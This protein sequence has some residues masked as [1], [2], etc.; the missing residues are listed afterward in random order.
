MADLLIRCGANVEAQD[1]MGWTPL[2]WAAYKN[3]LQVA[4]VLIQK[5]RANKDAETKSGFKPIHFAKL[6]KAELKADYQKCSKMRNLL[7]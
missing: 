6:K 7:Q 5:A 4:Q 1:N 3:S 2:H